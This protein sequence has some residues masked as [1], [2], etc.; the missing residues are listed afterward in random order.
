MRK[1]QPKLNR[2][3]RERYSPDPFVD[4]AYSPALIIVGRQATVYCGLNWKASWE[5]SRKMLNEGYIVTIRQRA[6]PPEL[7][8][9]A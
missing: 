3:L 1:N 9:G 2:Y 6:L 5:L 4:A 7:M 8:P